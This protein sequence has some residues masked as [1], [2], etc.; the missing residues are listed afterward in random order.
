MPEAQLTT[1]IFFKCDIKYQGL[2]YGVVGDQKVVN[3]DLSTE[4]E[5]KINE[6]MESCD[7]FSMELLVKLQPHLS[8]GTNIAKVY[9]IR[10]GGQKQAILAVAGDGVAS[11]NLNQQTNTC[12][13]C[14][15]CLDEKELKPIIER[16]FKKI[17]LS[18][19]D[20]KKEEL[21]KGLGFVLKI[22]KMVLKQYTVSKTEGQKSSTPQKQVKY[23]AL[24]KGEL[25][26]IGWGAD[27]VKQ[28][29][30]G[31]LARPLSFDELRQALEDTFGKIHAQ[32]MNALAGV[33]NPC[34][35]VS[36]EF[37]GFL[38]KKRKTGVIVKSIDNGGVNDMRSG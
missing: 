11:K 32:Q 3:N 15:Y 38:V 13:G 5:A 33:D 26:V 10:Y 2:F 1:H 28:N 23:T 37:R 6:F 17:N 25:H 22:P 19:G 35:I 16:V 29:L 21:R 7:K 34:P 12:N 36:R 8:S 24:S 9:L 27:V 18:S 30:P 20:E 31:K 4:N 14:Y